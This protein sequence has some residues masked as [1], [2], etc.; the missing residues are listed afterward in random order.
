MRDGRLKADESKLDTALASR[1]DDI[2]RMFSA[3]TNSVVPVAGGLAGDAL[4]KLAD[5]M[6]PGGPVKGNDGAIEKDL[7]RAR[8][9]LD[10][11][12]QRMSRVYER[13]LKQFSEMDAL[14][15]RMNTLRDNLKG[16]FENLAATYRSK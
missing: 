3:N 5:L 9:D 14:V 15:S 6:A 2:V 11:L 13:Y 7:K 12:Q 16:Q 10:A 8:E 4:F 1:Y